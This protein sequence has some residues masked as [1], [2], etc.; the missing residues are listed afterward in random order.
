MAENNINQTAESAEDRLKNGLKKLEN[1]IELARSNP[2]QVGKDI[3]NHANNLKQSESLVRNFERTVTSRTRSG[4]ADEAGYIEKLD[5][6]KKSARPLLFWIFVSVP[7]LLGRLQIADTEPDT[8]VL[9]WGISF[10]GLT[11]Q[12]FLQALFCIT[13]YY[14]AK[15]LWQ[16]AHLKLNYPQN[17]SFK[18]LVMIKGTSQQDINLAKKILKLIDSMSSLLSEIKQAPV[19]NAA[20]NN[21]P[22]DAKI[23]NKIQDDFAKTKEDLKQAK[24]TLQKQCRNLAILDFLEYSLLFLCVFLAGSGCLYF[25]FNVAFS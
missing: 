25:L 9:V 21:F 2:T 4:N 15:Y 19:V 10:T 7:F 17:V 11:H 20:I 13:T 8:I 23:Q 22:Q 1:T 16:F 6:A 3:Y 18:S 12:S 24:A 5:Q 14:F